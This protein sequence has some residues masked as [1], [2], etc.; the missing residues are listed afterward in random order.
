MKIVRRTEL[1][2]LSLPFPD[3]VQSFLDLGVRREFVVFRGGGV[4]ELAKLENCFVIGVAPVADVG[5]DFILRL[6]V[7]RLAL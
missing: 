3:G 6:G 2:L 4:N 5:V 1:G 7:G